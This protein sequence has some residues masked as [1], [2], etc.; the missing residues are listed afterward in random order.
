MK[1][2]IFLSEFFCGYCLD[3]CLFACKRITLDD[4][5][6]MVIFVLKVGKKVRISSFTELQNKVKCLSLESHSGN[7]TIIYQFS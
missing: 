6:F 3:T 5:Y 1:E 7:F 4:H 2:F